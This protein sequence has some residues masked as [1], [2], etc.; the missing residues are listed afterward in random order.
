MAG[1][2]VVWSGLEEWRAEVALVELAPE[3]VRAEGTQIGLDPVAYR[4]DYRL[5]A[6][7]GWVTRRL[8]VDVVGE[9]WR[10]RID[11]R[12]D[13]DGGWTCETEADGDVDL[14]APG[15]TPELAGARDCDLALSPLTNLMPVRRRDLHRAPGSADLVMAWVSVP[16]LALT[17]SPQHYEHVRSG[18]VRFASE[19]FT[20]DLELD[21][22]GLVVRYPEVAER[23]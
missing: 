15:G 12:H 18:V 21:E 6:T 20:A 3:G 23:A 5:D 8:E 14:P 16:D 4:A 10:R 19:G 2:L 7:G 1:R 9:G 22:D 11:L 17:A 13:G